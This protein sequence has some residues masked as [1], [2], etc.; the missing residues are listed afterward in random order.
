MANNQRVY[1][2]YT[3]PVVV[4]LF[5]LLV[6]LVIFFMDSFNSNDYLINCLMPVSYTHLMGIDFL[7]NLSKENAGRAFVH[8]CLLYTSNPLS[9]YSITLMKMACQMRFFLNSYLVQ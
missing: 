6:A 9:R 3:H 8:T 4:T 2:F 7:D 1:Y 5:F